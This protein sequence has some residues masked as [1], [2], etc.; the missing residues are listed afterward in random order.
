MKRKG[1]MTDQGVLGENIK[2]DILELTNQLD[3]L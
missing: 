2:E 3:E 1:I